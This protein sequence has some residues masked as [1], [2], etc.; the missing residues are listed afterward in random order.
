MAKKPETK[1][2]E[3]V[4]DRL[5]VIPGLWAEKIQQVTIRGTPDL[6]LCFR[7]WFVAWELKVGDNVP[8]PLQEYKLLCI[9]EAGGVARAVVS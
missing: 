6:L 1:F 9:Q 3:H 2:K 8:D 4:I 7:G 5:K